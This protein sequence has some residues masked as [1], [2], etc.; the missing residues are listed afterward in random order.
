[1]EKLGSQERVLKVT[2]KDLI[3]KPIP[4]SYLNERKSTLFVQI[5]V[6]HLRTPFKPNQMGL[7]SIIMTQAK[8]FI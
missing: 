8:L 7:G 4:E 3:C 5:A 6:Y 1:M 2:I